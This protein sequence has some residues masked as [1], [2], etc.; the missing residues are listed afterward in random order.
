MIL[1]SVFEAEKR[2]LDQR[3]NHEYAGI[4]GNVLMDL[5][6]ALLLWR[7]C[8]F[9]GIPHFQTLARKFD[10]FFKRVSVSVYFNICINSYS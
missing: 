4:A 3:S 5:F 6:L 9:V 2:L 1:D 10:F 8:T 7:V